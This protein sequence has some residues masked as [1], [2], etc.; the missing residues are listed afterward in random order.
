MVP[1]DGSMMGEGIIVQETIV[2]Y[3]VMFTG[4]RPPR[5]GGWNEGADV[6]QAVISWLRVAVRAKMDAGARTFVSGGALG[7]DQWGARA[8]LECGGSLIIAIPSDNHGD[9]WPSESKAAF[10][11]LWERATERHCVSP[12][13][14]YSHKL[15]FARD[16]W[17]VDRS[18]S[19]LAVWDGLPEGGTSQTIRMAS[20]AGRPIIRMNPQTGV[21]DDPLIF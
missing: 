18:A 19:V 10:L 8:V 15:N 11:D 2:K 21:V 17:M 20:Q 16:K 7:V 6:N 3:D 13:I 1:L 4:H 12:G 5:L 14:S 9:K